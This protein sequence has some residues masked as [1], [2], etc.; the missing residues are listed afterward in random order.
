MVTPA[1][2]REAVAHLRLAFEVSERRVQRSEPIE[3][4]SGTA[5]SG[6]MMQRYG[7]ACANWPPFADGSAIG[8][9]MF[10]SGAKASS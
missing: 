10:C 8:G 1:A 2:R 9:C 3:P 4:R 7:R 6:R 5:A